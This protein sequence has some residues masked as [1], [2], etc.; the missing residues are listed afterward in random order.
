MS[1]TRVSEV[2]RKCGARL[3]SWL[4]GSAPDAGR[5]PTTALVSRTDRSCDR[6]GRWCATH[7]CEMRRVVTRPEQTV[8]GGERVLAKVEWQCGGQV[9]LGLCQLDRQVESGSS[10]GISRTHDSCNYQI[11]QS[12]VRRARE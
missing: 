5:R 4:Q 10:D 12:G 8:S 9:S 7:K 11:S 3:Q 6:N 2:D 1:K